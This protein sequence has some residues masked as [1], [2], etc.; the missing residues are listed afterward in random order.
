MQQKLSKRQKRLLRKDGSNGTGINNIEPVEPLTDNQE[1]IF[2]S[3]YTGKN[4]M[5]HGTAGTGK[6]FSAIY[7]ALNDVLF[8]DMYDKLVIIRSVVPTRDMGFLPG[9]TKE[10]T[11]V[12]EIPYHTI[13]GELF[14][15]DDAY[16]VLKN[17]DKIEFMTTSYIRGLTISDSVVIIDEIQNMNWQEIS[18]VLTR[19][20]KGCRVILCG[21]TKQSDLTERTGK[22]DLLKLIKVCQKMGSFDFIQM[23][24]D[25]IIRS[26]FVK[27]F[28]IECEN[29]GY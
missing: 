10:K 3:Y 4:L 5:L 22:L 2:D 23:T 15:R 1:R 20:G 14:H 6:T 26:G 13:C 27:E 16:D 8:E 29:L 12:Y 7:L 19:V 24:R 11:R 9:N 17:K 21:D 28:I 25:D 18:S